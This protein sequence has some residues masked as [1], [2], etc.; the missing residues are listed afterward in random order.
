MFTRWHCIVAIGWSCLLLRRYGGSLSQ[1]AWHWV[2]VC[3]LKPVKSSGDLVT[4]LM[5]T[6]VWPIVWPLVVI[7]PQQASPHK[8]QHYLI[9]WCGNWSQLHLVLVEAGLWTG[10]MDWTM[11][12]TVDWDLDWV[13]NRFT[14]EIVNLPIGNCCL[15]DGPIGQSILGL[16]SNSVAV[17]V[18]QFSHPQDAQYTLVKIICFS[19]KENKQRSSWQLN[20]GLC[21]Y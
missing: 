14:L 15:S 8:P 4:K 10:L 12:S 2:T 11:E 19:G 17:G 20:H 21:E 5:T 18:T 9:G 16:C 6:I 7:T 3:R 13:L 1:L